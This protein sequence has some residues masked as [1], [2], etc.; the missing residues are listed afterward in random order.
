METQKEGED[1]E[2][3]GLCNEEEWREENDQ[4]D[5]WTK[6]QKIGRERKKCP[7]TLIGVTECV[8]VTTHEH[9]LL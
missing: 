1:E 7:K 5:R 8:I 4:A 3:E 6:R 9:F 2:T